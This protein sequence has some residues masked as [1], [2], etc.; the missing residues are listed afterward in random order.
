MTEMEIKY[1]EVI[2]EEM[3]TDEFAQFE[4]MGF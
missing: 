4:V 1:F 3:F 2:A